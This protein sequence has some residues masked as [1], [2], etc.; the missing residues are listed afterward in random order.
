MRY[1][2]G[3]VDSFDVYYLFAAVG[4]SLWFGLCMLEESGHEE[5]FL[6]WML[7]ETCSANKDFAPRGFLL[8]KVACK[9]TA[10]EA[11]LL[12]RAQ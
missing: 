5:I 11:V 4:I 2:N 12:R 8:E 6:N 3:L 7:Q 1:W 10:V 9:H